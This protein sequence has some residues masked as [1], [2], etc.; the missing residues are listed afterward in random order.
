MPDPAP[1]IVWFRN[2]LRLSDHKALSEAAETGPVVPV[3]VL[4]DV[5]DGT[6]P[7]GAASRWWLHQSLENL[8]T[9]LK[10]LGSPLVL[11]R[12]DTVSQICQIA[13]E[14]GAQAVH[15]TRGYEPGSPALE[16]HLNAEL[17]TQNI[18]CRR[19]RGRLLMEPETIK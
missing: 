16:K 12:G 15:L 7:R 19:F 10:A 6:W 8:S 9:A 2:A 18:T 5:S 17:E 4:D 14:T 1:T 11:R 13:T 3:F